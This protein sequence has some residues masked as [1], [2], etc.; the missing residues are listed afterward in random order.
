MF[1]PLFAADDFGV[2]VTL[3]VMAV[4]AIG[5]VFNMLSGKNQPSP[6]PMPRPRRERAKAEEISVFLEESARPD[7]SGQKS[8]KKSP[9]APARPAP[10]PL[11]KKPGS[12][13]AARH[14]QT[15]DLGSSVR[16]HASE[17]GGRR[18]EQNVQ[19]HM[20]RRVDQSVSAHL[21]QFSAA[22]EVVKERGGAADDIVDMLRNPAS[23]RQV[24]IL[25]TLL[26]P[27]PGFRRNS[28]GGQAKKLQ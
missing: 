12:E 26:S 13:M 2:I 4:S 22:P 18:V 24:M 14:L 21:G 19:D 15:S 3:I 9:Q 7:R 23:I 10:A 8:R 1:A 17:A 5:W 27:P 20:Q 28:G 16:T 11:S 25:N 6:P